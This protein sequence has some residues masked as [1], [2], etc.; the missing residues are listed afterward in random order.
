MSAPSSRCGAA[1]FVTFV[2]FSLV[3]HVAELAL[4][5]LVALTLYHDVIY[6]DVFFPLTSGLLILPMVLVQLVSAVFLLRRRGDSM[7]G[8]Q[9]AAWAALHLLQLA[10]LW[11]HL[12]LLQDRFCR[13]SSRQNSSS[14][15]SCSSSM[16]SRD[17]RGRRND[18]AELLTL[19]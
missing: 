1:C 13:A 10:F 5:A 19:R 7:A 18:L 6:R 11:R 17:S 4:T 14:N 15:T 2:L 16:S 12:M 3:S 9:V 8:C